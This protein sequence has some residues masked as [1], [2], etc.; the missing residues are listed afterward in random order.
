MQKANFSYNSIEMECIAAQNIN[1]A[2]LSF[3]VDLQKKRSYE[4]IL[5][6]N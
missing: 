6:G 4:I 2:Y 5:S 3:P 1:D